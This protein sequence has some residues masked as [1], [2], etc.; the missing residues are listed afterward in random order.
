MG[1]KK[2]L[3]LFICKCSSPFGNNFLKRTST[4]WKMKHHWSQEL[5]SKNCS[6]NFCSDFCWY[7]VFF[8]SFYI[9]KKKKN[10]P[11][12]QQVSNR[13]DELPETSEGKVRLAP[14][15]VFHIRQEKAETT[16][17]VHPA[18]PYPPLM[19]N[20]GPPCFP[21]NNSPWEGA[22]QAS[23]RNKYRKKNIARKRILCSS[24]Q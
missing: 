7:F 10:P 1:K 15:A 14:S 6:E 24:Q 3:S 9:L 17:T 20:S 5:Y 18:P 8:L 22:L 2:G 11:V 16:G 12:F 21:I 19:T 4:I 23:S 13:G